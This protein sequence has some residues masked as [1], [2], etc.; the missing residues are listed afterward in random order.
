MAS[1]PKNSNPQWPASPP[2]NEPLTELLT[3]TMFDCTQEVVPGSDKKELAVFINSTCFTYMSEGSRGRKSKTWRFW[4][5][6]SL[7]KLPTVTS[8]SDNSRLNR[9]VFGEW[10]E[11]SNYKCDNWRIYSKIFQ[12]KSGLCLLRKS[13]YGIIATGMDIPNSLLDYFV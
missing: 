12:V 13:S 10:Y 6:S 11:R 5:T 4:S 1:S 8:L 7:T 2:S 3:Q 9:F